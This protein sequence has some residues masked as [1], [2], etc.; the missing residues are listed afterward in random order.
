MHRKDPQSDSPSIPFS[1]LTAWGRK[2]VEFEYSWGIGGPES[3]V[4]GDKKQ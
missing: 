3:A 2:I 4:S 1:F